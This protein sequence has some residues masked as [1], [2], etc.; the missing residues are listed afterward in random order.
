MNLWNDFIDR[1]FGNLRSTAQSLVITLAT[2]ASDYG[3]TIS[4][5]HWM[6]V[7]AW[8]LLGLTAVYNLLKRDAPKPEEPPA[9]SDNGPDMRGGNFSGYRSI[10]IPFA[11]FVLLVAPM[12]AFSCR[13][14]AN[15]GNFER[16]VTAAG[17]DLQLAFEAG[18]KSVIA[19]NS[20]NRLDLEG[21]RYALGKLKAASTA[22]NSLFEQLEKFTTVDTSN[23][24][25]ILT[26]VDGFIAELDVI[27][28]DNTLISV[29]GQTLAQAR[30]WMFIAR[31]FGQ[32]IRIAIATVSAST[33]LRQILMDEAQARQVAARA[34][35]KFTDEDALLAQ[36]LIQVAADFYVKL[37]SQKGQSA[38]WLRE[39]RRNTHTTNQALFAQHL[40][41]V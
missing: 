22:G 27:I 40:Q 31:S 10:M 36:D 38:E 4:E 5:A 30:R 6:K 16:S 20:R 12:S 7:S 28:A 35:S 13:D 11:I 32:G 2:F 21:T 41:R 8:V 15:P 34:T 23:K 3:V 9:P 25:Q 29:D 24:D 26:L 17:Y 33:P 18:G 19:F 1:I 39:Q 37:K 14:S